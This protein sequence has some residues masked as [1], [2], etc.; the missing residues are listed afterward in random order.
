MM[1][2]EFRPADVPATFPLRTTRRSLTARVA[3]AMLLPLLAAACS[4][5][6][7]PTGGSGAAPDSLKSL[8][9][10]LTAVEQEGVRANT[11]FALHLLRATATE[12]QGNVLLSP[13]SVS[14]ALGLTM[15]GA[16]GNTLTEM[17][18]TLGW[19]ARSQNEINTA[20]RDLG[21]MLPTLD[22]SVTIR[23][24]NGVWT[25]A[26]YPTSA[27]FTQRARDFFN[28]PVQTLATPQLMYDSVNAWGKRETQNMIPKV[29]DGNAPNDLAMLLANAVYFAGSWRNAFETAKTK[30]EP[31][32]LASG[33]SVSVPM[34]QR[35]GGFNAFQDESVAAVEM[36]YGNGAYSMVF[37]QPKSGTANALAAR[38]TEA[39][40]GDIIR[41]LRP[42]DDESMLALPRF[43]VKGSKELSRTLAQMG[44]P[45]AFSGFAEFPYLVP[46]ERTSI[47]FVQH[48]VAL[49]V[50][51]QGTRAAAI[52]VVGVRLVSL[53]PS[54]RFDSPFVFFIRERLSGTI[55]FAGV[56]NDPRA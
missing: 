17:Q 21:R 52:T 1:P 16:A 7:G 36:L 24:A 9:R 18:Q 27:E 48:A 56:L 20:Y 29:L 26:G 47:G 4:E 3:A 23:L 13:L 31:F 30:P 55:L 5:S 42:A 28:A 22:N 50:F 38:L 6:G 25:R 45:T 34:M 37:V 40:F 54:Y 51:E 53:P 39:R 14:F 8:P 2:T 12:E 15:N 11:Q 43:S 44:M 32:R 33:S 49:D 35:K 19:G 46:T 10:T 41:G